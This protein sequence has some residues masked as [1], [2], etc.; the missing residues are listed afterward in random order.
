MVLNKK[1]KTTQIA[2]LQVDKRHICDNESI[3]KSMNDFVC[4]IGNT[5]KTLC[6]RGYI[7][8][9]VSK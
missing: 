9:Y 5:N 8:E 1:S 7:K 4:S 6:A 2:A 3:A